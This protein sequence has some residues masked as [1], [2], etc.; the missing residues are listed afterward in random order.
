MAGHPQ[1]PAP[2]PPV[3]QQ[4][5]KKPVPADVITAFQLSFVVAALGIVYL[6]SALAFAYGDRDSFVDQ[7]VDELAKQSDTVMSRADVE[8]LFVFAIIGIRG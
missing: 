3:Q 4:D 6:V 8:Q 7:V 2:M 5:G 1:Y